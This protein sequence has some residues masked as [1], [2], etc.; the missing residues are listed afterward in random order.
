MNTE[1]KHVVVVD[2]NFAGYTAAIELKEMLGNQH[3]ITV[4]SPTHKFLF[5]PSLIWFPFGT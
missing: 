2:T 5:Y 3:D 4:I 1:R